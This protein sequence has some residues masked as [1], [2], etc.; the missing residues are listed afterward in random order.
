MNINCSYQK[1]VPIAQLNAHPSNANKHGKRQIEMLAKI[2]KYQGWRHPIVVSSLSGFIVAG[3]G[4]LA[5]AKLNGW[6]E[7]PVDT[8]DFEDKVQEIAFLYSDNK[9]AELAE[10]DDELMRLTALELKL[11]NGFDLNLLGVPDLDLS[12]PEPKIDKVPGNGKE[13]KTCPNCGE[14]I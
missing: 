13:T 4:R 1:L 11:D 8:Q 6:T 7:C 14:A 10:H 12:Q 9:I 3:H 2:M 5:A